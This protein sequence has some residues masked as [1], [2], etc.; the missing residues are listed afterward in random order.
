MLRRFARLILILVLA[1][2][3]VGGFRY[4]YR[5]T[6]QNIA[7]RALPLD[8]SNPDRRTVGALTFLGAWELGSDNE[9]FGGIS[10]LVALDDGRF[11]GIS[12]AGTMIGFG[13]NGH[14]GTDRPF[15]AALPG[16]FGPNVNFRDRDSEGL[17]YDPATGRIWVSYEAHHAI[18]RFPPSLSRVDGFLPISGTANW[19][20]NKGVEAIARLRDGRFVLLAEGGGEDVY[21][22]FLYSGDPVEKGSTRVDFS[23]RPPS[24]YRPTDATPLPDGRLLVLNRRIGLPYGFSAKVGILDPATIMRGGTASAKTIATLASPLLVDNMEGITTTQENGRTIIWMISDDNFN[25][26]QRTLL[27]KFALNVAPN[28]KPEADNAPGFDSL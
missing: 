16:A 24:G 11:V 21:P 3:A 22:A 5:N 23:Y 25:I 18:R 8:G 9:Y 14:G 26:F 20:R 17:A 4:T 27:M 15:I 19:W 13:L 28:K 1:G 2:L 6:S 7:L 12:D 10:A